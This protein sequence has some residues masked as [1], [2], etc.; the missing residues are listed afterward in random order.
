MV[1]GFM[2][3]GVARFA[4]MACT[5][6]TPGLPQDC[7]ALGLVE[8]AHIEHRAHKTEAKR[9]TGALEGSSGQKLLI[10]SHIY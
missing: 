8:V 7:Q 10:Q 3:L 6:T 1:K 5:E 2:V 9:C 4:S